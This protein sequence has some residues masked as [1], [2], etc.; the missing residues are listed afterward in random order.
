MIARPEKN[1]NFGI[2]VYLKYCSADSEV[3]ESVE[4][5]ESVAATVVVEQ[6]GG[7]K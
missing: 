5:I 7:T 4:T 1:G 6:L 3:F 2:G